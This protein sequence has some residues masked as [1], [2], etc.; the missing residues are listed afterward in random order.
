V[1]QSDSAGYL[2]NG[3]E[4]FK[5]QRFYSVTSFII[6]FITAA[7]LTLFYR[8]VTLHW[9]DQLTISN[10]RTVA[11]TA[12]NSVGP[13]LVAYLGTGA[14]DNAPESVSRKLPD[15]LAANIRRTLH[16]T[17]VGEIEIFNRNG[18]RVFT[19]RAGS[20]G[21]GKDTDPAFQ[22]T[23]SGSVYSPPNFREAFDHF[24]TSTRKNAVMQTYVPIRGGPDTAAVGVFKIHTDMSRLI[25]ESD[26]VMLI[27]LA[28]AEVILALMYAT[29]IFV[30]RHARNVIDNQQKPLRER[31]TSLEILSS[32]L[33]KGDELKRKKIATNLHEGLAQTLS[34][35][36]VYVES[37][38]LQNNSDSHAQSLGA[39][40][41][42]LQ[43]AIDEVRTIATELRPSSL[44]DL[45]LLPTINWFCREFECR[46]PEIRVQRETSLPEAN[47]P[48]QLKID[49][50]R[51]IES[52]FKNIAKYSNTDRIIFALHQGGDMIHLTI[53]DTPTR[54]PAEEVTKQADSGTSPKYRFAEAME[55]TSLS[56]GTF[57]TSPEKFGGVTL[58]A[59]WA[60]E[61]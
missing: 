53:E 57:S 27:I 12:L 39:L 45:G 16:D 4:M 29:L 22:A 43:R 31:M 11:Q 35:L 59:S 54:P 25:D 10:N 58:R 21:T 17:T 6:I 24:E 36:K 51:I 9:I 14:S 40:V 18:M 49:I 30:V 13:E 37:S 46:H 32:R 19:T 23:L 61:E 28:G 52:A 5:L 41:P 8:Q 34:A 48:S 7:L 55:R 1:R 60:C 44:D 47:I 50:Y 2:K 3:I 38:K 15:E 42:V 56:G 33:L 20:T 26:R